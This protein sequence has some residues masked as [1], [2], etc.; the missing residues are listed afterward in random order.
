VAEGLEYGIVGIN[1]G[2]ISTEIAPLAMTLLGCHCERSE[3]ISRL[4]S[5]AR[6]E[7]RQQELVEFALEI[8]AELAGAEYE[9]TLAA[10][11]EGLAAER[12]S[13]EEV[14]AAFTLFRKT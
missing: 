6:P 7:N 2:I 13:D 1:E 11:D 4:A 10:I 12:A 14:K 3:A 8:A 5:L 9:A